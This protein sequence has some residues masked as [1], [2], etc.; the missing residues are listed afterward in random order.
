ML[1]SGFLEFKLDYAQTCH[2]GI[3]DVMSSE[4]FSAGGY[5][6]RINCY[7]RGVEIDGDNEHLS[8]YLQ[9]VTKSKNVKAVFDASVVGRDGTLYSKGAIRSVEVYSPKD[10]IETGWK[11]FVKRSDLESS[12]VTN[13]TVTILCGVNGS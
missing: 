11:R 4:N 9:L 13:G 8:I 6:W 7:P 5:L 2:L 10:G 12:Y 3:G 1:G